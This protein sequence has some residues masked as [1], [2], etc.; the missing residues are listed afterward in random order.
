M[1]REIERKYLVTSDAWRSDAPPGIPILQGYLSTDP[2]RSVRIRIA[3]DRAFVTIKGP[4]QG[5]ARAEYEYSIPLQ[6]AREMLGTLCFKPLIEK[7][8]YTLHHGDLRWEIDEFAAHNQG[9]LV[10][11][12]ETEKPPGQIEKPAWLGEDV[13]E[14]PRYSNLNLWQHPFSRWE[15]KP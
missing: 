10:A 4:P 12:V 11:E 9:L 15:R 2:R 7:T 6:D 14:D 13:T 8:R 5:S 3:G 1:P